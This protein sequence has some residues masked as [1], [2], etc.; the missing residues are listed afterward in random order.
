MEVRYPDPISSYQYP[1][2][3]RQQ[4]IQTF[5]LW[6]LIS[7]MHFRVFETEY[8]TTVGY[9]SHAISRSVM[10]YH[11]TVV[12][13]YIRNR[14]WQRHWRTLPIFPTISYTLIYCSFVRLHYR[15]GY[16]TRT[17]PHG[18]HIPNFEH[19]K[20]QRWEIRESTFESTVVFTVLDIGN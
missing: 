1:R 4:S 18:H 3:R 12:N 2:W 9:A 6:F 7:H 19:A 10:K 17:I 5:T 11:K 13:R 8:R 14:C 20:I 16:R 15:F